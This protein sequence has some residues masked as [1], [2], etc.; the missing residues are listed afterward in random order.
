MDIHIDE[1][2][3]KVAFIVYKQKKDKEI[4][5]IEYVKRFSLSKS[6][7]F[8]EDLNLLEYDNLVVK[9]NCNGI[10]DT[11]ARLYMDCFEYI[12][13]INDSIEFDEN[14]EEYVTLNKEAAIHRHYNNDVSFPLI[15]GIYRIKVLWKGTHYYS[16][17]IVKPNNMEIEEH[18]QMVYEI[19]TH[20]RGLARDWIRRNSSLD[21][22]NEEDKIDPTYLDYATILLENKSLLNKSM[23]VILNNPYTSLVKDYQL[24][25]FIKTKKIDS[26][27]LKM[28]QV[29]SSASLY[30][31]RS[32]GNLEIFSYTMSDVYDNNVNFYLINVINRFISILKK[33]RLDVVELIRYLT[34]DLQQLK[35]YTKEENLGGILKIENREKQ[36]LKVEHFNI[37]I[38]K[39][40]SNLLGFV[41]KSFLNDLI[42]PYKVTLSQQFIK[43]P[44]Y[45][46][47]Y[48]I[49]KMINRK[50][51]NDIE[52]LY[53]YTWKSSEVLYEYW[54][55]I[56]LIETLIE[57]EF[58][59]V[60][61]WIYS[62]E[63]IEKGVSIPAIPDDTF[64]LFVRDHITVKLL[65]NSAIGL[66]PR[67]AEQKDSP[68]WTRSSRNK[69]DFRLDIYVKNQYTKTII[70]DSKYSPAIRVWNKRLNNSS[71]SSK[72]VEQLKM[73][74]NMVIKINT[75]NT[76][77]VDEV[78][79]LCPTE[80]KNNCLLEHDNN[81]L[82]TIATMKPGVDN[83]VLKER[84]LSL[85]TETI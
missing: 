55:F 23:S 42:I 1:L 39:L 6:I 70:L 22:L 18:N 37:L 10:A 67:Q 34:N 63:S 41:K 77:V 51:N 46:N 54:C 53:D 43:T 30:N 20:A 31:F 48:M 13:E 62:T 33:A 81:H 49:F 24:M 57:S 66:T 3:F 80:I 73:Y 2:P 38:E 65:F 8:F 26:K 56:K 14:G 52:D 82:V 83:K 58:N 72:V 71:N 27:S 85:I 45:N 21:F 44:G 25:P 32:S 47:F 40:Q 50:L 79:V 78:I 12:D 84:L 61:G 17:V 36:I 74:V 68:Y 16:Q 75:R 11:D 59:P 4:K 64:V 15:P 19:E 35:R 76:H 7:G 60:D 69:P 29:K 9:L 28:S 5:S